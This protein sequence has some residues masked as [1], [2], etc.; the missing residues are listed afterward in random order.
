MG[1]LNRAGFAV[2]V[3][4]ASSSTARAAEVDV[5]RATTHQTIDGFGFFGAHDVWWGSAADMADEAWVRLVI[6]DLGLTVWRNEYYPPS[7]ASAGQDADWDKQRPVVEL[8]RDVAAER[9]VPLKVLLTVWSPPAA[10]K[11]AVTDA[12]IDEGTPNPGGTKEGGALCP[13]ERGAFADWLVDG[14]ALYADVGVDVYGLSLQNEPLFSEPYNSCVY[15]QDQYADTLAAV[16]PVVHGA[17]PDVR[18][19][20]AENMLEIECGRSDAGEFDPWWYT[21][22]LLERPDALAEL[23]AWAVHGYSDGVA[24][25]STSKMATLWTE[26]EA[27]V[28]D[29]DR[30][31]WMT[32]T[33]GYADDWEPGDLP[34]AIDL[35]QGI[36]AALRYGN[37]SAWVWWQGSE[38]DGPSEYGLMG[39]AERLSKRYFVSKQF[40]RYI[41]PGARRIEVTSDDDEVLVV[42]FDH[43]EMGALTLVVINVGEQEKSVTLQGPALPAD[44]AAFRSSATEDCEALGTVGGDAIVLPARSVTTL[45]NGSVFEDEASGGGGAGGTGAA[46]GGGGATGTGGTGAANT[47]GA[48]G[49]SAAGAAA[50]GG[51]AAGGTTNT[52][53]EGGDGAQEGGGESAGDVAPGAGASSIGGGGTP[54]TTGGRASGGV[55]GPSA[56]AA[57]VG[58]E[59]VPSGQEGDSGDDSGCGCA[60]AGRRGGLGGSGLLLA[61]LWLWGGVSRAGARRARGARRPG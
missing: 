59:G 20:G 42:G 38:L 5:D 43:P 28:R 11:C 56:A 4:L 17:F 14:L 41:R 15:D 36:F 34:G 51:R 32:E 31:I 25:T 10:M 52:G 50:V 30:P 61:C 16:G 49:S 22:R 55:Q 37:A 47:G 9:R 18:L 54:T 26:L 24:A 48:A 33:S 40:Y 13:A 12:G 53:G 6:D 7:D 3:T 29:T 2:L 60:A 44:F 8:F 23:G 45:V 57:G 35:A 19:F 1:K 21:G 39:G 27:A 58:P 46:S